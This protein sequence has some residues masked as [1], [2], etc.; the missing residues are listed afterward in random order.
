MERVKY[1]FHLYVLGPHSANV[2]TRPSVTIGSSRR[3]D[4]QRPVRG[5]RQTR[6]QNH[7]DSDAGPTRPE[8]R[9]RTLLR[10]QVNGRVEP[11]Q[12]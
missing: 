10:E 6:T 3:R 1:T 7:V 8:R 4:G 5:Q 11:E 9:D 12:N 2:R